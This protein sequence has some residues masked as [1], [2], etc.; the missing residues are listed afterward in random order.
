MSSKDNSLNLGKV[1]IMT[2]GFFLMMNATN[3]L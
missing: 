2:I 3:V 1:L